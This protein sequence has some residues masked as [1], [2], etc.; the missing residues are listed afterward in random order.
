MTKGNEG[1]ALPRPRSPACFKWGTSAPQ[2]ETVTF[3]NEIF[4][5]VMMLASVVNRLHKTM[6]FNHFPDHRYGV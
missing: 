1:G 4:N 5:T 3:G 6:P 2:Y